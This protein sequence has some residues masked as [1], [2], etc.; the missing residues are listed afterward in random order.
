MSEELR[1]KMMGNIKN[2]RN[3]AP[4]TSD[5]GRLACVSWTATVNSCPLN[6]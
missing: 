2:A 1:K 5:K 6:K 4:V 3:I